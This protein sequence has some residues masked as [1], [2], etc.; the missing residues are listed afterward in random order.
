VITTAAALAISAVSLMAQAQAPAPQQTGTEKVTPQQQA[1]AK[2]LTEEI[3]ATGCVRQWKPAPGDPAKPADSRDAAVPG[4]FLLTPASASPNASIDMPTYMLT[5]T[6]T[7]NFQQHL[8]KKVEVVG[9]AQTAPLPPTVQEI[10]TAPTQKPENRPNPQSMPR[11]TVK[12]M[13]VVAAT[14]P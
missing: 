9:I 12:T 14:C 13:K 2:N 4:I 1:Q 3:T 8:D 7:Q 5:P 6:A 10:A 11:L